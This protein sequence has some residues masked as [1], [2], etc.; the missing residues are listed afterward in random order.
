[1]IA[2]NDP[3]GTAINFTN[4]INQYTEHRCRL[5]TKEI[6]YNFM[7]EKDIHIPWI[8]TKKEWEEIEYLLKESDIIH[9]HMTA[10]EDITLGP[11]K[12]KDYIK[13]K[14]IVH[15]HHGHPDFRANPDKYRKKYKE[16]KR[17][18]LLVST[19][20]LIKLLPEATWIPNLIPINDEL[21][22]PI[23]KET[24]R[25]KI[26][27]SPT[28]RELKNTKLFINVI[29]KLIN[30]GLPVEMELIENT[31]HTD[32]LERKRRCHILFDHL[33]GYYGVSSL[34][35]L[36]QGLCVVAGIDAWC[37]KYLDEFSNGMPIPWVIAKKDNLFDKLKQLIGD[38]D[39]IYE[40]S[41]Y[42]R[43]YMERIW[44]PER[45]VKKLERFYTS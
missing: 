27:H 2:I 30:E 33:Q 17:N 6:R 44:N 22:K 43:V 29:N 7:Y 12:V 25:I 3:A 16:K 45:I 1:M 8:K 5:I 19:P 10:D 24:K 11:F 14:I 15:H 13:G 36:S 39:L 28:R 41:T 21:Y 42:S 23:Q 26:C 31:K 4:A 35:A 9:F 34:E 37:K 20:D 18:K 40:H 38:K 32:C